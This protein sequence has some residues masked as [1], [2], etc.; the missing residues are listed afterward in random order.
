MGVI[1]SES[2]LGFYQWKCM[3]VFEPITFIEQ[4]LSNYHLQVEPLNNHLNLHCIPLS[5][6][7]QICLHC[8][9]S[10]LP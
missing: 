5:V 1:W 10:L 8:S 3:L 2:F 7:S 6:V 4:Y 9:I